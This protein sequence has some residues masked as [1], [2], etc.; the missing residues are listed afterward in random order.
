MK[1]LY[2]TLHFLFHHPLTRNRKWFAIKRFLQWQVHARILNYPVVYPFIEKSKL[3][4]KKGMTGATGNIYTG[5]H[6]FEEMMFLLHLLRPG[7]L[8]CDVGANIGSYTVLASAV[9]RA[10]TLCF[11][12]VPSTF[13][14]LK[15]NVDIN[16][17]ENEVEL[18]N[19]GLGE[20]PGMVQFTKDL[21]TVNHVFAS[22]DSGGSET[23][24]VE[25]KTLDQVL[26]G[27]VPILIKIDVE[28]FELSVL[29]GASETLGNPAL[30]SMIVE[31]NGSCNRYGIKEQEIHA[32]ILS[33][34]FSS[35]S[36]Q[37]FERTLA[38]VKSF[39]PNGNTLYLRDENFVL[40]RLEQASPIQ[41]L[42]QRI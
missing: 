31:L 11:E 12:P 35:W 17:L 14:H 41:V 20:N 37:P 9:C 23:I 26:Q 15:H 33:A 1:N 21:D 4:I 16:D 25:I 28:G 40:S 8:F 29:K 38:Q 36:Y 2:Q 7:D 3:V 22:P 6:E 24:P 42:N 32:H 5:L 39:N 13:L 19:C 30:K 10:G 34:G 18:Y 27:R